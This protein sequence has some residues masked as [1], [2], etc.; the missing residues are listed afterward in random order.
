M[1]K[2]FTMDVRVCMCVSSSYIKSPFKN[3]N[4]SIWQSNE[5]SDNSNE[6]QWHDLFDEN[7]SSGVIR[8]AYYY[9][10]NQC[11]II[12]NLSF[13]HRRF[14]RQVVHKQSTSKIVAKRILRFQEASKI[15]VEV[16]IVCSNVFKF[17]LFPSLSNYMP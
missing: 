5:W 7:W 6:I 12:I 11:V 2:Y 14:C 15:Q 1:V 3:R 16:L 17:E 10:I 9:T 13:Q 4:S 8:N